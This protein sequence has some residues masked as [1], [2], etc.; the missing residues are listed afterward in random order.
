MRH[1]LELKSAVM[2]YII[3]MWIRPVFAGSSDPAGPD[4]DPDPMHP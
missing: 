1:F 3:V 2:F 4:P